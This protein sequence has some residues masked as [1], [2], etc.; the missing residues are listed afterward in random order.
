[1]LKPLPFYR[2]SNAEVI[3][4]VSQFLALFAAGGLP[5]VLAEAIATLRAELDGLEAL[6]KTDPSSRHTEAIIAL[7]DE[8]DDLYTGFGAWLRALQYHNDPQI[9]AAANELLHVFGVY[10]TA[11][12]VTKQSHAA[13]T[14]NIDSLLADLAAPA[15]AGAVTRT[16]AALW[17]VPLK[18]A[19]D[20]FRQRYT[21]RSLEQA[22]K[23]FS[24]TMTQKRKTARA[25]YDTVVRKLN[26]F[27]ETDG[28]R[29]WVDLTR[30]A[31]GIAAPFRLLAAR[32]KGKTEAKPATQA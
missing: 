13:E 10:G 26:G 32:R 27:L 20:A 3:Q 18:A 5:P 2:L 7:D 24:F 11:E 29:Q 15:L 1:M 12:K 17:T 6:H 19:N 30:D 31:E 22:T 25:A 8:R 4:V 21:D 14:T 28:G 23:E 9:E 16:G